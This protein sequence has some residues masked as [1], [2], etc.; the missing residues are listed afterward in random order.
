MQ[1]VQRPGESCRQP[2][3]RP[4]G[5]SGTGSRSSPPS[6]PATSSHPSPSTLKRAPCIRTKAAS[7]PRRSPGSKTTSRTKP[8]SAP[9][10][11][12]SPRARKASPTGT[13]KEALFGDARGDQPPAGRVAGAHLLAGFQHR[14]IAHN[15]QFDLIMARGGVM[16]YRWGHGHG[17]DLVPNVYWDTMLAN[18]VLWPQEMLG[19][20]ETFERLWPGRG[21]QGLPD[22][23]QAA[24]EEPEEEARQQ[25]RRP[26]RPRQLGGHGAVRRR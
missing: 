14:L 13:G 11:S 19:L 2:S 15:A 16:D 8:T 4:P 23:T 20:K 3:P 21:R 22:A 6:S 25:G 10:P 24:P 17:V 7:P 9:P 1:G 5:R 26:L 18:Y 12:P